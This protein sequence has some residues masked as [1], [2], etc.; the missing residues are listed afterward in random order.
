MIANFHYYEKLTY[1]DTDDNTC[2]KLVVFV[3]KTES[4]EIILTNSAQIS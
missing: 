4:Y 1:N 3:S 2:L